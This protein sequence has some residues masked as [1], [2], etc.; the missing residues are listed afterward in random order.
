MKKYKIF[1][2]FPA[3]ILVLAILAGCGM[4]PFNSVENLVR[5]PKL[6][7]D[8]GELQE[9]FEGVMGD[10]G[11]YILKYPLKGDYRTAFVRYD[12]DKD[13]SDEAFV[14]YSLKA[15]EMSV[16][17]YMLDYKDGA[18]TG[19]EEIPGEGNDIY[20]VEFC[21][22]NSD[23]VSELLVGWSSLD[24]KSNKRLSVYSSYNS[25]G[26]LSYRMLSLE[27]YTATY[28]VDIDGDGEMEILSALINSTSDTYTTEVRVFKMKQDASIGFTIESVGQISLFSEITAINN[29]TSGFENGTRYVY[30][31]ESADNAYLTE[32]LY[33][34]KSKNTLIAPI[35][36]EVL[37]VA[38]CPT[39]RSLPLNCA[40]VDGDGRIEIPS[41]TLI[42]NSGV[43]KKADKNNS[44]PSLVTAAPTENIY[45]TNWNK[46]DNGKFTTVKSYIE[47]S[48]DEFR[49]EYDPEKMS[50]WRLSFY[51]DEHISQ[52]FVNAEQ[53]GGG[54][55]YEN[56]KNEPG[57]SQNPAT[58]G[59]SVLIFSIT[60]HEPEEELRLGVDV[61]EGE[62]YKYTYEITDNGK[63][64]G[65][66][67]NFIKTSFTAFLDG[68]Q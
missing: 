7:G 53:D 63:E 28:T 52:F 45:V 57:N 65:I 39:T 19:V 50:D 64:A 26:V 13:G 6:P 16:S 31:D 15:E 48:Y 62:N 1:I 36:I 55:T 58:T 44:S 40:D 2:I 4:T 47:N 14:F 59:G 41:T 46:Y 5:P 20:S 37:S 67:S 49:I 33:W 21:D 30:I 56:A 17:M 27:P 34:D 8:E 61:I 54:K 42:E 32:I 24:S 12:C 9:A 60:A 25:S 66:T 43:I 11:E 29:I 18:W 10:K 51:P 22:L 23:G 3:I 38:S 68:T 35:N